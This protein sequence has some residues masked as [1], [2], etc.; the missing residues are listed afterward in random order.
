MESSALTTELS[1]LP[2][3]QGRSPHVHGVDCVG[4]EAARAARRVGA[5]VGVG[6][7]GLEGEGESGEGASP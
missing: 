4:H 6:V 1:R 5:G 2:M 7:G 3:R